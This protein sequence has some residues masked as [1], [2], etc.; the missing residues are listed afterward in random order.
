MYYDYLGK[1]DDT[2]FGS[3][4]ALA[5]TY[6]VVR[7]DTMSGIARK[8]GVSLASLISANPQVTNPNV[9]SIGQVL[10]VPGE[11]GTA[12]NPS[13][14]RVGDQV[15]RGD[16]VTVKFET[17]GL[18]SLST[19]W[20]QTESQKLGSILAQEFD[21]AYVFS[22]GSGTC[23]YSCPVVVQVT[24]RRN[25]N[26]PAEVAAAVNRAASNLRSIDQDSF[27]SFISQ[28]VDTAVP[29]N[30]PTPK[31]VTQV[32]VRTGGSTSGTTNLE[33]LGTALFGG[34]SKG[35]LQANACEALFGKGI[36]FGGLKVSSC[37]LMLGAAVLG[38]VL[39]KKV[40]K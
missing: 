32:P 3:L 33:D 35:N 13:T 39:V 34:A 22:S 11:G 26:S 30:Q 12:S 17:G 4:G 6:T 25:Y 28:A 7:G 37:T 5:T 8:L 18:W 36:E 24:A 1:S 14:G 40:I 10:N 29:I 15:L 27:E 38:L 21:S 19:L 2:G 9:I 20:S 31:P 23:R 16:R